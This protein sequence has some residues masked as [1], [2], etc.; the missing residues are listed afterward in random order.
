MIKSIIGVIAAALAATFAPAVLA[1]GKGDTVR[2]QDYPGIGNMLY[3]IAAT[4]GYCEK[5]GVTC[6]LQMIPSGP[7]GAQALLAK[8]TDVA[9]IGPDIQISAMIKGARLRAIVSGASANTFLIVIRDD[10]AAPNAGNGYP[11]F[12]ADLKGKRIGV[13]A[14]GAAA[15][16][17][18]V[19]L[20]Q[21][22]GLKAEDFTFVAVGSPNTAYGALISKQVDAEMSFP[23]S[24]A[25]CDV[26]KTCRTI[27][28]AYQSRELPQASTNMVVTQ[29]TIDKNAHVVDALIA[30]AEDGE[31]FIQD[32]NNYAEALQIAQSYFK[33]DM[34]KGDAVMDAALRRAIPFYKAAI[35]RSALKAFADYMLATKQ[36]EA[37]FDA[38]TLVY[39]KAP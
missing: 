18:F 9:F 22:A 33:F 21:K 6:Q 25:L 28:R 39:A 12:M 27:Y 37:P 34:P 8:S 29:E 19:V 35:S 36:I 7:L 16:L 2:I 5:H 32:P 13:P 10:L 38:T 14:R 20:A 15:E 31:A 26:L 24:D 30:A 3:R 17:Q 23:P 11:A 4:K 1:Q